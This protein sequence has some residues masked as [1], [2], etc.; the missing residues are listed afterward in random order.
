M[1]KK[2]S[3]LLMMLLLVVG[4]SRKFKKDYDVVDASSGDIPEWIQEPQEWADDEDEDDFKAHRYYVVNIDPRKSREIACKIAKAQARAEVASE[5]TA[6]I[7]NSFGQAT[8]GDPT[9]N[10]E[11][12][13]EYVEDTL[14][15]EVQ[16][17]VVGARVFRT[18]WE[19]RKFD[20]EKGAKKNWAGYTCS[21]LIKISKK[22]LEKAFK[23]AEDKLAGKAK[24]ENKQMVKKALKA[25]Q[26]EYLKI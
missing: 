9:D 1:M 16:A 13:S 15:Q 2:I 20:K 4:C 12:L 7:K 24:K 17:F 14:A 22:N 11:A 25:A 23:R 19:K 21:A 8:H 3:M 18:Y 6:F 26:D 10:D 5:V